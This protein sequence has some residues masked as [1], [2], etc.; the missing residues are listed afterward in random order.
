MIIGYH[1]RTRGEAIESFSRIND[2]SLEGIQLEDSNS[3]YTQIVHKSTA[4]SSLAAE[5]ADEISSISDSEVKNGL[6]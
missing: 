3:N 6:R 4:P 2:E 1:I 5:F